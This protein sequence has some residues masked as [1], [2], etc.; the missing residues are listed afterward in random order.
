M[1]VLIKGAPNSVTVRITHEDGTAYTGLT[2]VVF[3]VVNR[4]ADDVSTADKLGDT[5]FPLTETATP[6]TYTGVL[7]YAASRLLEMNQIYRIV[8]YKDGVLEGAEEEFRVRR[9]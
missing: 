2:D 4:S 8:P 9:P 3:Y 1:G 7:T 5:T 6:G